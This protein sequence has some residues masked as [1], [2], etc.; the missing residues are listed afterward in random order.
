MKDSDK[1]SSGRLQSLDAL[2][3]FDMF[4]IMGG[5]HI[6]LG[7]A[8]L[9]G[10]PFFEAIAN[11]M[12]HVAW[13]GFAF[14]DMIFPLFLFIAGISFPFSLSRRMTLTNKRGEIYYHI[15]RR[16]L[17]LFL[18]GIIY[19]NGVNF[20]FK[21]LSYSSVLGIIGLS[22][23]F[24]ALIF[25]NTNL[26]GRIIWF[27][28]LLIVYWLSLVLFQTYHPGIT[29]F[30]PPDNNLTDYINRAIMPGKF[31]NSEQLYTLLPATGT[32]LLGMFTGEYIMSG[33]CKDK[34]VRKVLWMILAGIA[35]I[36]IG[37]I[38]DNIF[39]INKHL[40]TSSYVC[41]VGGLS[42]LLFA[43]LYLVIEIWQ[44]KKW[45]FIFVVIGLNP[46]TIYF[47]RR[48]IDFKYTAGFFFDGIAALL[49]ESW[50]QMINGIGLTAVCWV[51]LYILYKKKI[52][53]KV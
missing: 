25:I 18:L 35:L 24:A 46:I 53:V 23:M 28:G 27:S 9:T 32:A 3:G 51:F 16:G 37:R 2:R 4:W 1:P 43:C 15:F 8:T 41:F 19:N 12:K 45:A 30:F 26:T 31:G 11:Q 52:F 14:Y 29:E 21:N 33:F 20:D 5:R 6:F 36:I 40:W 39:P 38:W 50:T 22:W 13:H 10:L 42:I 17:L 47:G 48:I 44:F 49:P 7:L 34:P